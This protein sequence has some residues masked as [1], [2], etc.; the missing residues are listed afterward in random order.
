M[1]GEARM[2]SVTIQAMLTPLSRLM[3]AVRRGSRK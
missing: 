2:E 3:S 1:N